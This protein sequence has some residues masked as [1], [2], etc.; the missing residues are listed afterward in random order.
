MAYHGSFVAEPQ[1]DSVDSVVGDADISDKRQERCHP[2]K[3]NL[4]GV[5][6]GDHCDRHDVPPENAATQETKD[7]NRLDCNRASGQVIARRQGTK[8]RDTVT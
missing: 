6:P 3:L 2:R 1:I 4:N 7:S 5:R 8:C